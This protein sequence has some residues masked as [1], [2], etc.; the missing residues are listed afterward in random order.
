MLRGRGRGGP[1][2]P[3]R[4]KISTP[5]ITFEGPSLRRAALADEGKS[6]GLNP[7][8]VFEVDGM[9]YG[10]P[11]NIL[12][13]SDVFRDMMADPLAGNQ[14][15]GTASLPIHLE[16]VTSAEMESFVTILDTRVF[17][18]PPDLTFQQWSAALH[19]STMW[20]FDK[21]R[22]YIIQHLDAHI[23]SLDPLDCIE[24]ADRCRVEKWL[25]PAFAKLCAREE[26]LS[27][28]EG[29][30]L[31][32]RRFAAICRIRETKAKEI[33]SQ[34]GEQ[35]V[36]PPPVVGTFACGGCAHCCVRPPSVVALAEYGLLIKK[37]EELKLTP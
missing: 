28:R 26:P 3:N 15:E 29:E 35:K 8:V 23:E 33:S 20:H 6:V 7:T 32:F 37:A 16:G 13:Q 9:L 22:N 14:N 21:T 4:R 5:L 11:Q 24:L 31:G 10:I 30:L 18:N 1:S 17:D 19:L 12:N 34:E 27:A 36:V 25:A 2:S